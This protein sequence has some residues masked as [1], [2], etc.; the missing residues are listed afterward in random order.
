MIKMLA[1]SYQLYIFC[2]L[3]TLSR[4]WKN[5][6]NFV[7]VVKIVTEIMDIKSIQHDGASKGYAYSI[8]VGPPLKH[9]KRSF[10]RGVALA[11]SMV[12]LM[13]AW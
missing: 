5:T 6:S 3:Y 1:F 11:G 12:I 13:P 10:S 8:A 2:S 4:E 9:G 7:F